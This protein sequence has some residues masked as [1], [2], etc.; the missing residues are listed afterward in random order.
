[1]SD[2]NFSRIVGVIGK[3][4]GLSGHVF[5]NMVTDYPETIKVGDSL[6]LDEACIQKLT[7]EDIKKINVRGK[8]RTIFKFFSIDTSDEALCIKNNMLYRLKEDSPSLDKGDFWIENL[9]GCDVYLREDIF[10]GKVIDIEKYSFNDNL[11]IKS[12]EKHIIIIP[13]L[14]D[15]ISSISIK[16]KKIILQKL[17]EYI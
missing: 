10:L 2:Q 16:E 15:Y 1:M 11:L 5:V 7:V 13:M 9:I 8:K 12:P 14:E 4:H 3:P 17:P 6:Y